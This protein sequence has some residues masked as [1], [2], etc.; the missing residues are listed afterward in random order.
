MYAGM[1]VY[2]YVYEY[3]YLYQRGDRPCL[4]MLRFLRTSGL[5]WNVRTQPWN[6]SSRKR[7]LIQSIRHDRVKI[8]NHFELAGIDECPEN[9]FQEIIYNHAFTSDYSFRTIIS[10]A[11]DLSVLIYNSLWGEGD[12]SR[13]SWHQRNSQQ[14]DTVLYFS[15]VNCVCVCSGSQ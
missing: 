15:N 12:K 9:S 14:T 8:G 10:I 7:I 13:Q 2:P 5:N 1:S 4:R 6:I 3:V 11:F